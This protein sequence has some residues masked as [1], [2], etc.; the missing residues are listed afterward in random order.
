MK[1]RSK[2]LALIAVLSLSLSA[3]TGMSNTQQ[4][5]LS[6]AAIGSGVGAVGGAVT[7]GCVS[8]GAAIG[9]AAGAGAGY[10][11]DQMEKDKGR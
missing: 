8:C 1:N 6:G 5:T 2:T 11:Y 4:R 3:C 10:V 9:A 7:G